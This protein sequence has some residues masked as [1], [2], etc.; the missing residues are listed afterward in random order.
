MK[1]G[2]DA[3]PLLGVRTGIGRYVAELVSALADCPDRPDLTL[4]P[5]TWR[6]A[7]DLPAALPPH[8]TAEVRTTRAPARLL[9]AA[10]S[11][12]PLPPVELLAGAVDVFHGTNFVLP[13][14]ARAAGVVTVHDLTFLH[15]PE[16]V[17][18]DSRRYR[19][20][21]PRSIAAADVVCTPTRAVADQV[22]AAYGVAAERLA[23]TP[24]GVG[25]EWFATHPAPSVPVPEN[26]VLFIGALEPRKNLATLIRGYADLL[27]AEPTA[28]PL[29]L[30]GPAG[31]GD[32]LPLHRL[33]AGK[34][35]LPGYLAPPDLHAVVARA[36]VLAYPS[37]DEGFGLP[38]LEAFAAGTP[39]V[40]SDLP[41]L[42]EV[43]GGHARF[44]SPTDPTALA[45][46]IS[47]TLTDGGPTTAAARRDH[48]RRW[49]WAGCATAT[50]AAYRRALSRRTARR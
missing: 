4:V 14:R 39:V 46:A 41:A 19:T 49:T 35:V 29:V 38:P 28:P 34:V 32:A 30:A 5:F 27:A 3:T 9:R 6:G 47:R 25:A 8:V 10:W 33:P 26:Y 43:L 48:A 13:P 22:H 45:G 16:W 21:V 2:L 15:H 18:R 24:L 7:R 31:W 1:V 20:L 40:A 11:R 50:L 17:T 44:V 23:V 37:L 12:T 36:A 42:R